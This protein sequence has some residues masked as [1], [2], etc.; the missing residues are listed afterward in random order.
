MDYTV[1]EV[2]QFVR[3]NDIKFI[4]LA[5]SDLLGTLKNI[6]IM[7]E[8]LERA[9]CDGI[10]F[11]ASAIKGFS[12][13]IK[14]DLFLIPVPSTINVLPWRPQQGRVAR[15]FCNIV[16]PA[17][18]PFLCDT[19]KFLQDA[20]QK[21]H[22]MG[23]DVKIGAECEF[24]LFKTDEHGDPTDKPYDN[25]G[26]LDIS[27]MDKGENIRREICLS[28]EEMGIIP[29]TSH[30]EQGP[31]QNEIDFRYSDALSSADN[32][33][34]FKS[35]VKAVAQKNGL[36]A[37]FMPKPIPNKSGNGLHINMSL[38]KNGVNILSAQDKEQ[39][40][41][42]DYFIAGIL[43]KAAEINAFLCQTIN[44]YD[45]LGKME[46]PKY[47][48]WSHQN[49]SQLIRIPAERGEKAR[50]ELRSPDPALNP[51]LSFGLLIYAGL[52]GIANKMALK[53]AEDIDTYKIKEEQ[54]A[55][56]KLPTSLKEAI[57]IVKCSPFID[58]YLNS[59]IKNRFINAKEAEIN[60]YIASDNKH[61]FIKEKYFTVL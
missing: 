41:C 22:S 52:E 28:L 13:V 47:V 1:S 21:A 4:R 32:F 14:S 19:R 15:F 38:S 2:M 61:N 42:A 43:D 23:Y 34:T 45:R 59:E 30:H 55:S 18:E 48:S 9:L 57:D 17:K 8:E 56:V 10:S 20:V 40:K 7:P 35:T 49:R 54:S 26:Y 25:G 53:E 39:A 44:S 12:D 60:E 6:S 50:M 16:T 51:Y 3:E 37:S 46:A 31:G 5:F 58:R 36:Y 11:D 29:E 33:F 27:P 24:Y